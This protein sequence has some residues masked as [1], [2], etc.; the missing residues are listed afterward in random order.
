MKAVKKRG[1]TDLWSGK[2]P[3]AKNVDAFIRASPQETQA[4]L[5]ELRAIVRTTVPGAIESISYRMP[6][7]KLNGKALVAFAGFKNHIGFYPM[8]GTF[9]DDYKEELKDYVT[10]KGGVQFPSTKPLPAALLKKLLKD[11]I[12]SIV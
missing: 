6:M 7:Y 4:K 10:T 2:N 8:S 12:K 3:P 9:L 11:R 5:R 1:S